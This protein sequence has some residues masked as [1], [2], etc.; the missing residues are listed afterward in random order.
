MA[1]R[2]TPRNDL[3]PWTPPAPRSIVLGMRETSFETRMIHGQ[4]ELDRPHG[5]VTLPIFQS[6]VFEYDPAKGTDSIQYPR[7][8]NTPTH[9]V[10]HAQLAAIEGAEDALSFASGMSAVATALL[11]TLKAGDHLLVQE[12]LYGG[13]QAVIR[14]EL[15]RFGITTDVLPSNP[16][17]WS[18]LVKPSTR[19]ILVESITNP[20]VQVMDLEA[21]AAFARQ[22]GLLSI[23]DNTFATPVNYRP[24]AHG[25]DIV[26]HSATKYLNG[27]SD[28]NAGA[29]MG[30]KAHIGPIRTTSN[31]FGGCLDPHAAYLLHR[32]IKTLSVRV[33][34]Q[35]AS[36]QKIAGWLAEN[37]AIAAVNYPGLS[38]HPDH[39]RAKKLFKGFG[40]M[41]SF[42][43]R[44]GET[45]AA[46]VLN[47]V[48]LFSHAPS[49]GGVES[50]VVRPATSTHREVSPADRAKI[51][52]HDDL[53]RVSVGLEGVD[54]LITDLE[55]ALR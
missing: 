31:R 1:G 48:R 53:I 41:L 3:S 4:G 12:V 36:A 18:K 8:N 10:L 55:Q 6:T 23:I 16:A 49:L 52:I 7:L 30:S 33:E 34:R 19:A 25:F 46:N 17:D 15:P 26:L 45:A 38:S 35:N 14:Y 39:A 37:S 9:R 40:G 20:L 44:G 42:R 50:L 47:R 43:L 13:T 28:L 27:H 11:S 21:A 29:L 51:G 2:L 54:D 32:G 5:S 24:L 22:H